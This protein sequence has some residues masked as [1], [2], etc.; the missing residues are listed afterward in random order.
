[1]TK[2]SGIR[3]RALVAASAQLELGSEEKCEAP[4]RQEE[5]MGKGCQDSG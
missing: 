2:P 1:M 4:R 3:E 5:S